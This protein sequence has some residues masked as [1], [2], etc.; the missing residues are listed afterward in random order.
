[1][2]RNYTPIKR[3]PP[4]CPHNDGVVCDP[5]LKKC[6]CCGWDPDVGKARL[7]KICRKLGIQVPYTQEPEEKT[8]TES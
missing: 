8:A 4:T 7:E 6:P 1:M 2:S 3:E 5:D